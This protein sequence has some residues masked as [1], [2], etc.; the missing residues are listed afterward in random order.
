MDVP[1]CG[2]LEGMPT[3]RPRNPA[4]LCRQTSSTSSYKVPGASTR[5]RDKYCN[6]ISYLCKEGLVDLNSFIRAL[7]Q[8]LLAA[9]P[10]VPNGR[11]GVGNAPEKHGSLIVK[12]LLRFPYALVDCHYRVIQIWKG[13]RNNRDKVRLRQHC[14]PYHSHE[15]GGKTEAV[16]L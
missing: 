12:L 8:Y 13:R 16:Q 7:Q 3:R 6:F 11:I 10:A 9:S 1:G 4:G 2:S 5:R 14:D 15:Q